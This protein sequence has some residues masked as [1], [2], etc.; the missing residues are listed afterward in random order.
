MA[1]ASRYASAV[2]HYVGDWIATLPDLT[3]TNR[4]V[5]WNS[6]GQTLSNVWFKIFSM[7]QRKS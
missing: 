1:G 5:F 6:S 3:E 7:R 4:S 2:P